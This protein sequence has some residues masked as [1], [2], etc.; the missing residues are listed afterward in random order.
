[1][2]KKKIFF[3]GGGTA[4]P[5]APLLAAVETMKRQHLDFEALWIGTKTGPEGVLARRAAIPFFSLHSGK[6]RR[7]ASVKNIT[8]LFLIALGFFE[9]IFFLMKRRPSVI[10]SAGGYAAV[11]VALAG[12]FLGIP[13]IIHQQDVM[14]G[15]ANR[16][17]APFAKRV[18][19]AFPQS[20]R[21]FPK[22]KTRVIGNPAR[23]SLL[24]GTRENAQKRFNLED[25]VPIVFILGGGTG[26]LGLNALVANN[27]DALTQ[28]CQIIHLTGSGKGRG[29]RKKRYR[30]YEF[31][32]D[33]M[34]DAY[35]AADLVV[36]RAGLGTLSELTL[37]RK[38]AV[39]VP[40][41]GTHQEANARVFE[42]R[43]AARV[44]HE[45]GEG[46]GRF[47]S[48]IRSLL[49]DEKSLQSLAARAADIF[50]SNANETFAEEIWKLVA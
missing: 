45:R 13:S 16:I 42:E 18:T 3:V 7:Y 31:F 24:S 48:F 32:T 41:P 36:G 15:L 29:E 14:P 28:F 2:K 25:G 10:V 11:P 38:P 47:V 1:M 5:A 33:E 50:P 43:G 37:L 34:A 20:A 19:V 8:D 23:L 9:A 49:E 17:L 40:L 35:A 27:L 21:F 46:N 22:K 6:W 39:L 30:A 26:A 44:F 4:G 12:F